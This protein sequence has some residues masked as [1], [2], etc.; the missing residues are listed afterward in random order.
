M[1]SKIVITLL[2]CTVIFAEAAFAQA[3]TSLS[4]LANPT[5]VN[6]S[7]I[8][9][10]NNTKDLGTSA[11]GWRD[12][13]FTGSIY[14]DGNKF[15]EDTGTHNNYFGNTGNHT[16]NGEDNTAVGRDAMHN[17]ALGNR[18]TAMGYQSLFS[19]TDGEDNTAYG[20]QSLF[21]NTFGEFNCAFGEGALNANAN[22]LYNTAIGYQALY[23]TDFNEKNTASGY[24]ALYFNKTDGNTADGYL[25]LFDN[26]TGYGNTAQG[27]NSLFSNSSGKFNAAIGDS[28]GFDSKSGSQNTFLGYSAN[29]TTG[30]LNNA[31]AIGARAKVSSSNSFVL[32]NSSVTGWGF[33]VA[34]STRAILVGTSSTNGNGAYLTTGGAW[35]NTSARW[36]KED[37][38]KQDNQSILDKINQLEVTKWKY[39]GTANEYH[40]GPMADDFHRLFAVGDDSSTSDLDKTGVLFLGMQAL[41][42]ENRKIECTE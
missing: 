26:T 33:G 12:A 27:I 10:S 8:P 24:R 42:D 29:C 19:N 9:S 30:G 15:V 35:T 32:G 1:K 21:S 7:L 31:T 17:N 6:R 39:K 23:S 37:F 16:T 20:D 2:F 36:K 4:N 41:I 5:S 3:N 13:Y 25:S 18:N 34:P 22:G 40:Y 11:T 38:Q 14:L 28:A